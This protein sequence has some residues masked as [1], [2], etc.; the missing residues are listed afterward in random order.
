MDDDIKKKG[1]QV[2]RLRPFVSRNLFRSSKHFAYACRGQRRPVGYCKHPI[3]H[4]HRHFKNESHRLLFHLLAQSFLYAVLNEKRSGDFYPVSHA[5]IAVT[6]NIPAI[7]DICQGIFSNS[8]SIITNTYAFKHIS[9]CLQAPYPRIGAPIAPV[10]AQPGVLMEAMDRS[11]RKAQSQV[12][13]S[14]PPGA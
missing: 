10:P 4:A 5:V 13:R 6:T 2:C 12:P 11:D 8:Q 1:A 3:N 7:I 9:A 14:M